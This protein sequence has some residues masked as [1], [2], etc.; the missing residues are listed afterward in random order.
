[1][2]RYRVDDARRARA[3]AD[4]AGEARRSEAQALAAALAR[5]EAAVA[6]ADASA[7]AKALTE[8]MAAPPGSVS[9]MARYRV[10][11]AR[12]G[13][14]PGSPSAAMRSYSP[15]GAPGGDGLPRT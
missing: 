6:E 13:G 4:F 7:E 8:A 11:L 12:A 9:G 2:C 5:A 1:M 10:R 15:T 14:L 3:M